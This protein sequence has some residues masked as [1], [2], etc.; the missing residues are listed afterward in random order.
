MLQ[1][2]AEKND[3][4]K[5]IISFF[6]PLFIVYIMELY[7]SCTNFGIITI[8][9]NNA[10]LLELIII[11]L[12][13][14]ILY[15][16]TKKT[17]KSI[18]ILSIIVFLISII[19]Q[20]KIAFTGEPVFFTD[21]MYLSSSDELIGIVHGTFFDTIKEYIIPTLIEFIV[22]GIIVIVAS[23]NEIQ[24]NIKK[25]N[26][27][28]MVVPIL[29]ITILFLPLQGLNDFTLN[30]F[31]EINDRKDYDGNTTN[32]VYYLR[33][34][35][36][37]GMYGQLLE[38]RIGKPKDYNDDK[39]NDE[40]KK[41]SIYHNN[42]KFGRPNIIVVFSE[43]FWDIGQLDEV[44]FD[45]EVASNFNKLKNEGLFFDMISPSYGG[46]SANVE[47]EFLTGANTMYF[48]NGYIPYMQLYTNNKYK[49]NPSIIKEIRKN[50]YKTKITTCA[51]PRLFNCGRFYNYLDIDET[52]YITNVNEVEKKG[53]YISDK[54]ITDKIINEFNNK[55]KDEK[56][57]YMTL[58]MQA[59]MPYPISKYDNYDIDIV[60]SNLSDKLNETLKS[61]AQGI[62]DA[63]KEL[64]R[65]YEYIKQFEEPTII[66]F[67][68]D[69]LPYLS[70]GKEDAMKELNYFNTEDNNLNN[71]R[72]YN[73]Q[74]LILANFE[75][76]QEN[77]IKYL[78]PDLLSSYILNNMDIEIS[79]YYKWLYNTKNTIG[80]SN[81]LVSIDQTGKLYKTNKLEGKLKE[82]YELRKNMQY[83]LFI[84]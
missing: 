56:I 24:I 38:N 7:Y 75:I 20:I 14:F 73:T 29:I 45:R 57:F 49:N 64:G 2:D 44:K 18:L 68:G 42:K 52:E 8:I 40:L 26:I 63:D 4:K 3:L 6:T 83:K 47:F 69:H 66:I 71:F 62:Y 15:G 72:K 54:S 41:A 50:G 77:D 67:Y 65:L 34:G 13:F 1:K 76:E 48:N 17:G 12:I 70:N 27:S 58:T 32:M 22:L 61:Y 51:S 43:S 39:L 35:I 36:L 33:Y 59:H 5:Y 9:N 28:L 37:T 84:K 82:M 21:I 31:F 25:I 78:G 55:E 11:Y 30:Y 60:E 46:I 81:Y 53:Q 16:L 10:M 19:N 79:D 80:A 23:K 74:S